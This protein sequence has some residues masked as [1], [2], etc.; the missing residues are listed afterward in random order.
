MNEKVIELTLLKQQG[1]EDKKL[2]QVEMKK[3][4]NLENIINKLRSEKKA[5]VANIE[6]LKEQRDKN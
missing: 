4:Q 6:Q 2:I 5:L 3:V 1:D